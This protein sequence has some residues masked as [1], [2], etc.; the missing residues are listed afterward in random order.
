[1]VPQQPMR[2][3]SQFSVAKYPNTDKLCHM[4][5]NKKH[6]GVMGGTLSVSL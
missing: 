2:C 3:F 5:D 1:M 4:K 6:L